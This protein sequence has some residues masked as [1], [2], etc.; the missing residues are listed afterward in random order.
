MKILPLLLC[1]LCVGCIKYQN[2]DAPSAP[3]AT[4]LLKVQRVNTL[5]PIVAQVE[6][7]DLTTGET[8]YFTTNNDGFLL[9]REPIGESMLLTIL[10]QSP[11]PTDDLY[12]TVPANGYTVT[13]NMGCL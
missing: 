6:S 7:H 13:A 4:V 3:M 1:L 8:L 11:C 2:P 5:E 10:Q 9:L 12:F